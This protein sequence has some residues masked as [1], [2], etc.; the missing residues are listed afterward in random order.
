MILPTRGS[1]IQEVRESIIAAINI[2]GKVLCLVSDGQCMC[3]LY[4][5]WSA[6]HDP[7]TD[8]HTQYLMLSNTWWFTL[9]RLGIK[10]THMYLIFSAESFLTYLGKYAA[11][12][13][14]GL[15][16]LSCEL[17]TNDASWHNVIEIFKNYNYKN[18]KA[19]LNF[20]KNLFEKQ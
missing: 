4:S 12:R 9:W 1:K 16:W 6:E 11:G 5:V 14:V 17:P 7:I 2:G 15:G 8:K 3:N 20:D 19:K 10:I 18:R 13:L